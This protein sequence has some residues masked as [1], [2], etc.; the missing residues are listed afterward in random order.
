M[1]ADSGGLF[2]LCWN[3]QTKNAKT[4][5]CTV[6]IIEE[7]RPARREPRQRRRLTRRARQ[8][9]DCM[10]AAW[11][12]A[13]EPT[14]LTVRK[15]SLFSDGT[16]PNWQAGLVTAARPPHANCSFVAWMERS[17]IRVLHPHWDMS[18]IALRSIRA[19]KYQQSHNGDR[20]AARA[21]LG[22]R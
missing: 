21:G 10:I 20:D 14:P 2:C 7:F 16:P 1:N 9:Q 11:E 5:P 6:Q 3:A 13:V 18:R 17:V 12:L 22:C 19:T 4:T 15:A 8:S